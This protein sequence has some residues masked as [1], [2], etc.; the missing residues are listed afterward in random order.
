VLGLIPL[1]IGFLLAPRGFLDDI[2]LG[3][4]GKGAGQSRLP[5]IPANQAVRELLLVLVAALVVLAAH[6]HLKRSRESTAIAVMAVA[7]LPQA[8]QRVDLAHLTYAGLLFLPLVPVLLPALLPAKLR[9]RAVGLAL[10]TGLVLIGIAGSALYPLGQQLVGDGPRAVV[11]RHDGRSLLLARQFAPTTRHL[12]GLVDANSHAGE[13]LF[14][15]D[16]D[17]VR[18]AV[19]DVSLYY[20]LPRLLNRAKHVE[21]TPGVSSE[22]GSGLREDVLRADVIVLI[23]A[24]PWFR[25]ALFPYQRPGSSEAADALRSSFCERGRVEYYV[26]YRRC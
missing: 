24:Q 1:A 18:P 4:A 15:F 21:I 2:V 26:I 17:L 12:L 16:K 5:L 9:P 3:R 10:G 11:V 19:N 25:R 13:T 14:V 23:D 6:A 7:T 22:A 8:L 20:L